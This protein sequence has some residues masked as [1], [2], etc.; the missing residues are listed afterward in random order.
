[1]SAERPGH[2]WPTPVAPGEG[3]VERQRQAGQPA[4]VELGEAEDMRGDRAERY[5]R[6]SSG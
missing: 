5:T 2:D 1:M 6:R 4:V 3:L